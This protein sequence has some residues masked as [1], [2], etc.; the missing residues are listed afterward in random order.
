MIRARVRWRGVL[1]GTASDVG[2]PEVGS[3][4]LGEFGL[5]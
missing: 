2:W 5:V 3:C 4:D 1:C